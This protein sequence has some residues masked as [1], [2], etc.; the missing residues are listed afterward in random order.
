MK[1]KAVDYDHIYFIDGYDQ[2]RWE[3]C[4][5]RLKFLLFRSCLLS[6]SWKHKKRQDRWHFKTILNAGS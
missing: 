1:Y 5:G 6:F 4:W 3:I 2:K